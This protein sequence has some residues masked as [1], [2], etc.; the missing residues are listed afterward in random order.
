[1]AVYQYYLAVIPLSG[2]KKIHAEIPAE[3][4][5]SRESGFL[6]T[7]AP[8]YWEPANENVKNLLPLIDQ[9]LPRTKWQRSETSFFWKART[10]YVDNDAAIH[11]NKET[12]SVENFIFRA[13]LR[14]KD[15]YFLMQMLALAVEYDWM[16]MDIHG[17][18]MPP[19]FKA[20][21][22][23]IRA[24]NAFG[25]LKDPIKFLEDLG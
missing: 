17:K 1:M 5:V 8:R 15:L 3:L 14:E 20:V 18:L 23:S 2:I 24:S 25:F 6:E 9:L 16:L 22:E 11:L 19:E 21:K 12:L 10:D 4:S 7:E 13:D